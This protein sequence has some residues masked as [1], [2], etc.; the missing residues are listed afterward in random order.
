MPPILDTLRSSEAPKDKLLGFLSTYI[1]L[2]SEESAFRELAV[3]STVVAPQV[4]ALAPG[5]TEKR[6]ALAQWRDLLA[7]V[8][9]ACEPL[10]RGIS[11]DHALF[12][13]FT[14]IHGL[15]LAAATEP[16]SLPSTEGITATSEAIVFGLL[17]TMDS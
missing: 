7:P 2:L 4:V 10:R 11:V 9:A 12:V 8:L 15:T 6:Q 14:F 1:R 16:D 5:I 3:V 13:I 17:S